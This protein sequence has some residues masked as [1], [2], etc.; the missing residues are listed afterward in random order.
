MRQLTG[1]DTSF[2]NM[3]TGSQFGH[4][5]SITI[6]DGKGL[7]PGEFYARILHLME[8]RLHLMLHIDGHLGW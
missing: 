4:V 5:A 1:L 8:E 3:E 6:F 7:K 2:L